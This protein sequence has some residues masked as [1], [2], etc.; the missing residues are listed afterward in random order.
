[1]YTNT[2]TSNDSLTMFT[3]TEGK[4]TLTSRPVAMSAISLFSASSLSRVF[5]DRSLVS[6]S[7]CS[8]AI[9]GLENVAASRQS[10]GSRARRART[11][12]HRV[13]RVVQTARARASSAHPATTPARREFGSFNPFFA[14][15]H[16]A[17]RAH[18]SSRLDDRVTN[19]R[20]LRDT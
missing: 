20:R 12:L 5:V 18:D 10:S 6:S 1:M 17:F 4:N 9:Y 2:F 16:G 11:R 15:P 13:F 19:S 8:S 3:T 14:L 7:R